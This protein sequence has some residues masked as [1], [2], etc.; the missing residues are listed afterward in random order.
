MKIHILRPNKIQGWWVC[1]IGIKRYKLDIV[2][3]W[4]ISFLF[5]QLCI[6]IRKKGW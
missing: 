1:E 3:C 6:G 2:T 4:Y 5:W